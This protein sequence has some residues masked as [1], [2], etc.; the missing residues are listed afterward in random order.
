MDIN[1]SSSTPTNGVNGVNG[2]HIE[3]DVTMD[4]HTST[5]TP[6][7]S[8]SFNGTNGDLSTTHTMPNDAVDDDDDK[9][10]PAKRAR[11]HSIALTM[12]SR[13]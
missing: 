6:G 1:N 12:I 3:T 10:L 9:P 11:V 2:M 7:V 5:S 4:D 13:I 8:R